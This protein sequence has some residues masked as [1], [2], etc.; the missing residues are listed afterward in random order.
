[1]V[2]GLLVLKSQHT[3]VAFGGLCVEKVMH[4]YING[5]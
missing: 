5:K 1:M 3:N 4:A 2:P